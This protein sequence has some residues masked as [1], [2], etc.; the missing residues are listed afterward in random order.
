ML[1]IKKD[2]VVR[3]G[4]KYQISKKKENVQNMKYLDKIKKQLVVR[5]KIKRRVM[6]NLPSRK[7]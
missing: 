1:E 2:F 3:R 7:K 4:R 6:Q 5:V